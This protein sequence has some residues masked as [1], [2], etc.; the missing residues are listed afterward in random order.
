MQLFPKPYDLKNSSQSHAP[1]RSFEDAHLNSLPTKEPD[2]QRL[3]CQSLSQSFLPSH[4]VAPARLPAVQLG[5][6]ARASLPAAPDDA[7]NTWWL[8]IETTPGQGSRSRIPQHTSRGPLSL[9]AAMRPRS[10]HKLTVV[11]TSL[12]MRNRIEIAASDTKKRIR[13]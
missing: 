8:G 11:R 3:F 5:L 12:R 2:L 13:L 1:L 10:L 7:R 9:A 4:T 6:L